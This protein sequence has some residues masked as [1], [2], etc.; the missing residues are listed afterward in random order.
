MR[1]AG[2]ASGMDIDSIVKD[3]MRAERMPLDKLKQKKQILEWQRDDYRAINTQLLSFRDKLAQLKLT[4]NYRARTTSSS[5]DAYVS[6]T[7]TSGASQASY[8][9]SEVTQLASAATRVNAAPIS[10]TNPTGALA[11]QE[12]GNGF[13]WKQGVVEAKTVKVKADK[14]EITLTETLAA[15]ESPS[16]KVN[17]KTLVVQTDS[18]AELKANEVRVGTNGVLEFGTALKKDDLVKI[19]YVIDEKTVKFDYTG[20]NENPLKT[21]SV[22][23]TWLATATITIDDGTAIE[24]KREHADGDGNVAIGNYGSINLNTGVILF[25]PER[26]TDTNIEVSY[27]QN[28]SSFELNTHTSKGAVN[29]KIFITGSDSLNSVIRKVNESDAGVTMF[30]DSFTNRVTLTRKETGDFNPGVGNEITVTGTFM[31]EV[32]KFNADSKETGG[33]NAMFTINGLTTER[34]SNTFDMNGVTFTLKQKFDAETI[35]PATISIANDTNQVFEN[36]KEF[37]NQYNELIAEISGKLNE[38]R[39]R[40][41]KPLTDDEREELSDKQQE[42]WEEMA[43]SGLLKGDPLL[44]GVLTNMRLDMSS[45]VETN[46]LF[47]QLASIGISTTSNYLDGGKLQINEAKLKEAIEQDPDSVE[48]LFR[49]DGSTSDLGI[50]HK[51]YNTVDASLNRLREKAGRA[52]ST[53]QQF[54]IGRELLNVDKSIDRFEAKM[55]ITEDRYWR[56]FTAME[57]AIQRANQQSMFLMNQFGGM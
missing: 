25:N 35:E 5:N 22:G 26:K 54:S 32:L 31:E 30:Y 19:D 39:H 46:G 34:T 37:V 56:Q 2:L 27:T 55:K 12:L 23:A 4:S 16:I 36:I 24:V 3:L 53:N 52:T 41:Y 57:K 45:V 29:E 10:L 38:E 28:Y 18:N 15:G 6:A 40:S 50:I 44:S 8:S 7:A 13:S 42:K 9:I 1:I 11:T 20:D 51:L 47:S 14:E 48:S 43:K 17:G 49:S 21:W 33:E